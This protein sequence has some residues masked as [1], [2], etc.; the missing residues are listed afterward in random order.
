M[1]QVYLFLK[2]LIDIL[3]SGIGIVFLSPILIITTMI[4]SMTG[5]HKVI[6]RQRRIGKDYRPFSIYKFVTMRSDSEKFG[7]I[8]A[9]NDPRV[10]PVGKFLRKSKIN[11]L[12]QLFNILFGDMSIVGP[13]PLAG[14]EVDMYP[15]DVRPIVYNNNK[16]GLTGIGSLFFRDEDELIAGTEKPT[17]QAYQ[18]DIMPVKGRLE[19]WYRENKS[20]MVDLLIVILTALSVA[21]LLPVSLVSIFRKFGTFPSDVLFQY[22]VLEHKKG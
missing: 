5:E 2:R 17:E 8:T 4:L 9:K 11:E 22:E 15:D 13:R 3:L 10:L 16:P 20:L 14:A 19:I 7:T 1:K 18:E 12:P 6:Y 21:G